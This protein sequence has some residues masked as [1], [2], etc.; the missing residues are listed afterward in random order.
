MSTH[1]PQILLEPEQHEAMAELARREK[2]SI[3][4]LTRKLHKKF[5]EKM[6][7]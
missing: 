3:S 7:K 2:R 4:D 1:R 5:F 6:K